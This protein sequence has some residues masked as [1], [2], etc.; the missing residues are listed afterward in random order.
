MDF[1]WNY[2]IVNVPSENGGE[3]WYCLKEVIYDAKTKKPKG[4]SNPCV[5]S[6]TRESCLEVLKMF[7][8]A[9]EMPSLQEK[10]FE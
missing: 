9:S 6:E 8:Y 3:D 10:D 2:R 5:G 7:E 4:Y 1:Y